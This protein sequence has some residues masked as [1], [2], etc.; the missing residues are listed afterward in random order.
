MRNR[1][2]NRLSKY[3]R[4]KLYNWDVVDKRKL[5]SQTMIENRL[6][7]IDVIELNED[8]HRA[9]DSVWSKYKNKYDERW[10]AFY[11]TIHPNSD[12][13]RFIPNDFY[14]SYIDPYF[15]PPQKGKFSMIKTCTICIFMM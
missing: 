2:R 11:K 15:N 6:K 4:G 1:V 12:I 7:T 13:S 3:M 14:Y 8:D 9:I 5:I 10:F